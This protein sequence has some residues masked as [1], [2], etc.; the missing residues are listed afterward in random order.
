MMEKSLPAQVN[1]IGS[2]LLRFNVLFVPVHQLMEREHDSDQLI[3]QVNCAQT[4]LTLT[5]EEGGGYAVGATT[6]VPRGQGLFDKVKQFS[7]DLQVELEELPICVFLNEFLWSWIYYFLSNLRTHIGT[8]QQQRQQQN[9][10]PLS[11]SDVRGGS[12]EKQ[13]RGKRLY[14]CHYGGLEMGH[15]CRHCI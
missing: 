10:S 7:L 2:L 14:S 6:Q 8:L 11:L 3:G 15:L 9:I 5:E 13:V 4:A 1:V 12:L